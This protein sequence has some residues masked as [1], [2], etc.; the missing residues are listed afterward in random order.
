MASAFQIMNDPSFTTTLIRFR[1]LT[2]P[3]LTDKLAACNSLKE[4]RQLLSR[5]QYCVTP[6][7][8]R[9]ILRVDGYKESATLTDFINCLGKISQYFQKN[10]SKLTLE[11]R[12]YGLACDE[13]VRTI[14]YCSAKDVEE[15]SL[16]NLAFCPLSFIAYSCHK[17]FQSKRDNFISN[18]DA[19]ILR[20]TRTRWLAQKGQEGESGI[21]S[22][23]ELT[24]L[25]KAEIARKRC[26]SL[27]L[28][29]ISYES[30]LASRKLAQSYFL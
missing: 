19:L 26:D 22:P 23:V 12:L 5:A 10:A 13:S 8:N 15:C 9:V 28:A 3:S 6:W 21:I 27:N 18:G 11:N 7:D 24:S 1:S 20:K 25:A 29:L 14:I 17:L 16:L 4:L 30:S 2:Y